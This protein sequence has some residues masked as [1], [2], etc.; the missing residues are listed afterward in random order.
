MC[1]PP[2][3][4]VRRVKQNK[5]QKGVWG[6]V[7]L[8]KFLV[9]AAFDVPL[10]VRAQRARGAS[11]SRRWLKVECIPGKRRQGGGEAAPPE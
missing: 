10:A 6:G 2:R 5:N 1:L 3:A 7:S 9:F 4:M 11:T 8:L